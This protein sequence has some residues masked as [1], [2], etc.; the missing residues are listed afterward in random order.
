MMRSAVLCTI[1]V[2]AGCGGTTNPVPPGG[3]SFQFTR[4]P[5]HVYALYT[6]PV[7]PALDAIGVKG[8]FSQASNTLTF[9]AQMA[10]PIVVGAPNYYVWGINRGGA[11][12]APFPG[13]PN[14]VFN[15][16]V[17]VT[18]NPDGTASGSVVLLPGGATPLDSSAIS[19]SQNFISE[20][21]PASLL[22]S[23]G[24]Q[25]SGYMWNLWPRSGLGGTPQAQIQ[26]FAPENAELPFLLIP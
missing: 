9:T 22:P 12:N 13:E 17:V 8:T 20:T 26:T 11:T 10:G 14:I 23:T 4:P 15:A 6:G 18:V 25:I 19:I 7:R 21:F 2:L 5:G 16:V 1:L 24:A 3:I